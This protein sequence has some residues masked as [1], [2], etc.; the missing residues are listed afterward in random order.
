MSEQPQPPIEP[1]KRAPLYKRAWNWLRRSEQR[2]V[3]IGEVDESARNVV[4]GKNNIQ[5]NIAGR[6][7]TL[8]IWL[9]VIALLA[10]V[11]ILSVPFI[12]PLLNPSQMTAGMNI[13][14]TDFGQMDAAGRIH[15]STLGSTLSK[16]VF[17]KLNEEYQDVYPELIGKD[18]RSVEIWHD[19][20]GTDVKNVRLGLL[21]GESADERAAQAKEL[22]EKINAHVVIYGYLLEEGNQ[23]SLHLDFYYA[24]DTLRGEPDTIVGRHVLSE[25][26]SFPVALEQE[27]MA[28]QELLNDSLSSRARVLFWVTVALIF[29]VTDQQERALQTLQEAQRTLAGSNDR[30]GQALLYYFIGREAFWL[31]QYDVAIAAHERA[32]QLKPNYANAYLGLGVVHFDRAQLFYT[33]Q[34]IPAELAECVTSE[35]LDRAAQTEEEVM[36]DIDQSLTYLQEAVEIAPDSPWPPIEYPA[37]LALG[38]A[39]RLK[40]QAYLLDG[41]AELA[42]PWFEKAQGEFALT[43]RAFTAAKQQQYLA[44]THLGKA[45]TYLLQAYTSLDGALPDEAANDESVNDEAVTN[46]KREQAAQYFEQAAE[47]CQQC[48][49]EGKDVADLVY[50]KKVLRCGC[51]Y[52]QERAQEA[53][54]VVQKLIEEQ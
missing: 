41:K 11:A 40:G 35:H 3:V 37:R 13:A 4:I 31:R 14:I 28:V 50:Q 49:D 19:S 24:G 29:D 16:S 21:T 15:R 10:V 8:P 2:D 25:M 42:T 47:E 12:N 33:P 26:L 53:H 45:A 51:A 5:I 20:L 39:Y 23:N 17:D 22:A 6:L 36:D 30:E 38:N 44:W 9:F 1:A 54:R 32:L 18:G 48:L 43:E 46:T 7:M 34:P 27:P 52:F